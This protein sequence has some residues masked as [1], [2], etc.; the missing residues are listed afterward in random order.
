MDKFKAGDRVRYCNSHSGWDGVTG[1]F[2]AYLS[3]GYC[4]FKPDPDAKFTDGRDTAPF[5]PEHGACLPA[6]HFESVFHEPSPQELADEFRRCHERS[7]EIHSK[8]ESEG[9]IL[10]SRYD[11]V[12]TYA[13]TQPY[14]RGGMKRHYRFIKSVTTQEII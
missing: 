14:P 12:D 7:I 2:D 4:R 1:A 11:D 8:L 9:Y 10:Q 5:F 6:R 13:I 3:Q